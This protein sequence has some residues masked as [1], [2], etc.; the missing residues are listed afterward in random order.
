MEK[1]AGDSFCCFFLF[2]TGYIIMDAK[3]GAERLLFAAVLCTPLHSD[4]RCVFS[5]E[6]IQPLAEGD[7]KWVDAVTGHAWREQ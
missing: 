2:N 1:L 6:S 7:F 4:G 5:P 3:D